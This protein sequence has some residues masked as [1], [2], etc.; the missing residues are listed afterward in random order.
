MQTTL[1]VLTVV[2]MALGQVEKSPL[3]E[4]GLL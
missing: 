3:E 1:L 2:A 4:K